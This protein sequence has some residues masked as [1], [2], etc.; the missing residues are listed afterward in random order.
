MD[1]GS[2]MAGTVEV[3][4]MDIGL[5]R[6]WRRCAKA[7]VFLPEAPKT[8]ECPIHRRYRDESGWP[9]LSALSKGWVIELRSTAS[10]FASEIDPGL[11][12]L[13]KNLLLR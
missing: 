11:Q 6:W 5:S 13:L 1:I 7:P 10:A 12:K 3:V 2:G 9:I 8:P 4:L